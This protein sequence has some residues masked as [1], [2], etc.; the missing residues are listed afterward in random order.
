MTALPHPYRP[1]WWAPGPH[2]QTLAGKLLRR[3][4]PIELVRERWETP[5]RD[6]VDLDRTRDDT[7]EGPL[8]LVLHGL[9]GSARRG[10]CLEAYRTLLARG[11]AA[12]GLNFRSCSGEPN[13]R[14]RTY[15]SGETGDAAWVLE[16]LRRLHPGRPLGALGF[17]LGGNV[18]LKLLGERDDGGEGLLDAAV[19]ISVPYDLGAGADYLDR[20]PM[21]RLYTRYFLRSL[22]AKAQDKAHLL[23][24]R[25][26]LEALARARNLRT[27]DDLLTAPL[28]GFDSAEHY[29]RSSS[30]GRFLAGVRVPTLLL[31]SADDPF[32]PPHALPLDAMSSNPHLHI[33]LT[34]QGG[35]VGFVAGPPRRPRFWAEASAARF[36]AST[37]ANA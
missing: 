28:H 35:H 34:A 7:G 27:F 14:P 13:L 25:F 26:D 21:R 36:L 31:H 3:P 10:Y 29:Y 15:H 23:A 19:A 33:V 17:S 9:E 22:I 2:A 1:A 4:P 11:A 30:A 18:L 16:R 8:V 5:D 24:D 20:G 32:L 37:L 6:F 12:V